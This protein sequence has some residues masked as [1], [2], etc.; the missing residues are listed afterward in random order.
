MSDA[1]EHVYIFALR[2]GIEAGVL[3]ASFDV[4][5]GP[6]PHSEHTLTLAVRE[7]GIV[8]AGQ[9]IPHDWLSVG[10]SFIDVR[11]SKRIAD[12]LQELENKAQVAG[13]PI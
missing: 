13:K 4:D 2:R 5:R 7:S 1:L 3:M 11:Y 10:T 12:L 9:A 8:V 6:G